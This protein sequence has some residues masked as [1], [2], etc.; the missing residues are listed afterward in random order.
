[1]H[2]DIVCLALPLARSSAAA[3]MHA[4]A[5]PSCISCISC[6]SEALHSLIGSQAGSAAKGSTPKPADFDS[7]QAPATLLGE[8]DQA[9]DA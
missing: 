5:A 2:A 4:R 3:A 1:M 7:Y 9:T 6:I 8:Y